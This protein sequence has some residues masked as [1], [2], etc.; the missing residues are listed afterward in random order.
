MAG[1]RRKVGMDTKG[2]ATLWCRARRMDTKGAAILWCRARRMDTKG[3]ATLWCRARR[4]VTK[5]AATLWCRCGAGP[6]EWSLRELSFCA[7]GSG[8]GPRG[9]VGLDCGGT[10]E[11][12]PAATAGAASGETE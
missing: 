6:G 11:T 12:W 10:A 4:M 9:G 8:G 7:A 5:G 1:G 3:A 2:A